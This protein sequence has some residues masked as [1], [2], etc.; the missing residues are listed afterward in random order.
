MTGARLKA[1]P[2]WLQCSFEVK[3]EAGTVVLRLQKQSS[4]FERQLQVA[5]CAPL[6]G[7]SHL[8]RLS[9]RK[10][11]LPPLWAFFLT[12]PVPSYGAGFF[13]LLIKRG[14]K[15]EPSIDACSLQQRLNGS[16]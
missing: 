6:G 1:I 13:L 15:P 2:D 10:V 12:S 11:S 7:N 9:L 14:T 5:L 3:D 16:P 8:K 4:S